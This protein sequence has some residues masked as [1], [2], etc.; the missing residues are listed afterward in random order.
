ML[1][2]LNMDY[3]FD[4]QQLNI[5]IGQSFNQACLFLNTKYNGKVYFGKQEQEDFN[6]LLIDTTKQLA[7]D[8]LQ[9]RQ[10]FAGELPDAKIIEALKKVNKANPKISLE[11]TD[12][13]KASEPQKV[14]I[15]ELKLMLNRLDTPERRPKGTHEEFAEQAKEHALKVG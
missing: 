11:I 2:N 10:E 1:N 13:E 9:A 6:R 12:F 3:N 4:T 8:I 14:L 15:N 7:Q 5:L